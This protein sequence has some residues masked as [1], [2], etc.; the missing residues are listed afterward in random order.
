MLITSI[1]GLF[2]AYTY[3]LSHAEWCTVYQRVVEDE[4]C[5]ACKCSFYTACQLIQHQIFV[6]S[7]F[8]MLVTPDGHLAIA[9]DTSKLV[10]FDY[11]Q[12]H[13]G[14]LCVCDSLSPEI[15]CISQLDL[16]IAMALARAS[17]RATT[18]LALSL[19]AAPSAAPAGMA[20]AFAH[21]PSPEYSEFTIHKNNWIEV[22]D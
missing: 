15:H 1:R 19:R 2:I 4:L 11:L 8:N 3:R 14:I 5:K 16:L 9:G 18:R 21:G 13:A 22:R 6:I 20:R 7:T 12:L 10:L 17:Q